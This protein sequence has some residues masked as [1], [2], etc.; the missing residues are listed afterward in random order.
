MIDHEYYKLTIAIPYSE[1][2]LC[3]PNV[4]LL[5]NFNKFTFHLKESWLCD[6]DSWKSSAIPLV[7]LA[8][9]EKGT[10]LK[11]WYLK[12]NLIM[13]LDKYQ[14]ASCSH[15]PVIF[16]AEGT[17]LKLCSQNY[18]FLCK[19]LYHKL[20]YTP[21]VMQPSFFLSLTKTLRRIRRNAEFGSSVGAFE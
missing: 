13:P 21:I 1:H 20:T 5:I 15:F 16:V 8:G 19:D 4:F 17:C 3:R 9:K 10:Y 12:G 2:W 18:L 14:N 6:K 11:M 7:L